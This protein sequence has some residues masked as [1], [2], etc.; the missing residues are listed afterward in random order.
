MELL[1]FRGEG[2]TPFDPSLDPPG[3][4]CI[5]GVMDMRGS[6]RLFLVG[7]GVDLRAG[8]RVFLLAP[9]GDVHVLASSAVQAAAAQR[10][11]RARGVLA[12]NLGTAITCVCGRGVGLGDEV[13]V[14]RRG[15]GRVVGLLV[16]AL[17]SR[18]GGAFGLWS[19][20]CEGGRLGSRSARAP[21]VGPG[22]DRPR[23]DAADVVI[24]ATGDPAEIDRAIAR[25]GRETEDCAG[26]VLWGARTHPVWGPRF[27]GRRLKLCASQVSVIPPERALQVGR[28]AAFEL[29][30]SIA[31]RRAARS[32]LYDPPPVPFEDAAALYAEL[33]ANPGTR[34]QSVASPYAP[35]HAALGV[36]DRE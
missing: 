31:R 7:A 19:R 12:A 33:D 36:V 2:P 30:R 28:G 13:V 27:I 21:A 10:A 15:G 14:A 11:E 32:A 29:V 20:R 3:A 25:A 24:R 16:V 5:R 9:H 26:V 8:D 18:A 1:L 4:P 34:L 17:A 23:G 22:E 6:A 35:P